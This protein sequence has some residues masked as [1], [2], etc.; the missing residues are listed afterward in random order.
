[1]SGFTNIAKPGSNTSR[2]L[3]TLDQVKNLSEAIALMAKSGFKTVPE[4][5]AQQR[6][7]ICKTCHFWEPGARFGI[8]KCKRCGCSFFK[9]LFTSMSCP[10]GSWKEYNE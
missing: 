10:I 8:G 5:V 7:E 3:S 1:M 2:P 6:Q 4:S 9:T